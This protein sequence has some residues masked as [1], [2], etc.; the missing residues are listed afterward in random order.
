M[1]LFVAGGTG[2]TGR[3]LIGGSSRIHCALLASTMVLLMPAVLF[4][5]TRTAHAPSTHADESRA[6]RRFNVK[7]PQEALVVPLSDHLELRQ[8]TTPV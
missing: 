3:A 4:A 8:I 1:K 7:V 5:Q 2:V 6:V